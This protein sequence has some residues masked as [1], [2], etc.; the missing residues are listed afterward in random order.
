MNDLTN[1]FTQCH[2]KVNKYSL[3]CLD[4]EY[5]S[6]FLQKMLNASFVDVA[7]ISV[8]LS[9]GPGSAFIVL[10]YM[11]NQSGCHSV[12]H[13]EYLCT[14]TYVCVVY[15]VRLR[16]HL[17][18]ISRSKIS[19]IIRTI[20]SHCSGSTILFTSTWFHFDNFVALDIKQNFCRDRNDVRQKK[21]N[22]QFITS[23]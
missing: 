14:Y 10:Y 13:I 4:G 19:L 12:T 20:N 15:F 16:V 18:I 9:Q 8:L 1:S 3:V 22:N 6:W 23:K 7:T 2:S 21:N 5:C 17:K 11:Q